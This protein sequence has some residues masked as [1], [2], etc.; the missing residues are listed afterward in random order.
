MMMMMAM[1]MIMIM[2][3]IMSISNLGYLNPL[4]GGLVYEELSFPDG[5][6]LINVER[7]Q[8]GQCQVDLGRVHGGPW[9]H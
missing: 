3:L 9:E 7:L 2:T 6:P 1:M 4:T 5:F 8:A